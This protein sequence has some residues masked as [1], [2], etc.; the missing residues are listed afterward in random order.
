[1]GLLS[2][3]LDYYRAISFYMRKRSIKS[4]GKQEALEAT[5]TFL[6]VAL[7]ET[8]ETRTDTESTIHHKVKPFAS[9]SLPKNRYPEIFSE[10]KESVHETFN[11]M[12]P[13]VY[14][15]VK[16]LTSN[17][18]DEKQEIE[19]LCK[20]YSMIKR[21]KNSSFHNGPIN[22]EEIARDVM[23][24]KLR[25]KQKDSQKVKIRREILSQP[26]FSARLEP[27]S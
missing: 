22:A 1:M 17:I 27:K 13:R 18:Q 20:K 8:S 19:R 24:N 7:T 6:K 26:K 14:R 3:L 11:Q 15:Q 23:Q 5:S 12:T 4:S 16:E 25:Q 21:F 2:R 9:L 10:L